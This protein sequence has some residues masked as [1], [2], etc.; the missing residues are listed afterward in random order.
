MVLWLNLG[1]VVEQL[2]RS[3]CQ[4]D[5]F[6][7]EVLADFMNKFARSNILCKQFGVLGDKDLFAFVIHVQHSLV[8]VGLTFILHKLQYMVCLFI[9][10]QS[11]TSAV[12][13]LALQMLQILDIQLNV[14]TFHFLVKF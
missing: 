7:I 14:Q 13:F 5:G 11:K 9:V 10:I 1:N 2:M 8:L 12:S 4:F 3:C 6:S